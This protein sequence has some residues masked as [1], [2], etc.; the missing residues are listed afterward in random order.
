MSRRKV[1]IEE[2]AVMVKEGFDGVDRRF[3]GIDD[4]LDRIEK[5]LHVDQR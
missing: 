4:R 1:T 2:L 3:D 5:L